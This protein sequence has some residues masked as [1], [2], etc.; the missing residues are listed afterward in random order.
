MKYINRWKY[1]INLL[2]KKQKIK[3]IRINKV[4]KAIKVKLIKYT[5]NWWEK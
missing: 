5:R 2:K 4:Q 1:R 3:S